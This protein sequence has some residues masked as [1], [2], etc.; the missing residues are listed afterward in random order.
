MTTNPL[1][2]L[3]L[4]SDDGAAAD[5][6]AALA[7]A[8]HTVLRCHEAGHDAFPCS[9]LTDH[10]ACPLEAGADVAVLVRPAGAPAEPTAREDGVGCALRASVP[11]V[12]VAADPG[13]S[14][15]A[16]WTT[17]AGGDPVAAAA[18]AAASAF[19]PLRSDVARRLAPLVAHLGLE[20]G[21][22]DCEIEATGPALHLRLVG[23]PLPHGRQQ[24]LSVRALDAVRSARRQFAEISVAYETV[25]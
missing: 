10:G 23:P 5:V 2:V 7:A 18:I 6:A 25:V 14:P 24:A 17:P 11:V 19:A 12:E 4:E 13:A 16:A 22:V 8:G 15:F 3:V 1:A 21:A 20:P 9:G